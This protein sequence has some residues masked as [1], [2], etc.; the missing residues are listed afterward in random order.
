MGKDRGVDRSVGD[1]LDIGA[2]EVFQQ[3][4]SAAFK[5]TGGELRPI[6]TLGHRREVGRL[7]PPE[8]LQIAGEVLL[9]LRG[10]R[11]GFCICRR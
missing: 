10:R 2:V 9:G 4:T 3:P 7:A 11:R 5:L 8:P 1:G 6:G